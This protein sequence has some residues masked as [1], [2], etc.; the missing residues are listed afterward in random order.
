M[1]PRFGGEYEL[2]L[3]TTKEFDEANVIAH[4]QLT[5]PA[6]TVSHAL[7]VADYNFYGLSGNEVE[8]NAL[9]G[10]I[11]IRNIGTQE[12]SYPVAV[13]LLQQESATGD[14]VFVA[15]QAINED[16][17][18][19]EAG[20]TAVYDFDFDGLLTDSVYAI[21]VV[22]DS[23][24]TVR[25]IGGGFYQM[26]PLCK[27]VERYSTDD[28]AE[29][30]ANGTSTPFA[31][32]KEALDFAAKNQQAEV[33]LLKDITDLSQRIVYKTAVDNHVCTLDLNGHQI[34]GTITS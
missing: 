26:F 21:Q 34:S 30:I 29:V 28:V 2:Y 6:P 27:M 32:L 8:G 11:T 19:I 17:K 33:R 3:L 24:T 7:Q 15:T 20:G 14:M 23:L 4:W 31:S 12:M 18:I 25:P 16:S 22:Y 13:R 5:V 1:T 9:A 10:N